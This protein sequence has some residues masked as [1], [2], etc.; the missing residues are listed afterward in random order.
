MS[1]H[2]DDRS[3][4][5]AVIGLGSNIGDRERYIEQAIEFISSH[6]QIKLV[7]RSGIY[8]TEPVG[9]RDQDYFLN[10]AILVHT[11]LTPIL[12]L[13]YLLSVEKSLGRVRDMRW[14]PRTIDLDL[15]L[16]GDCRL[17]SEELTLPHPRMEERAFV[18]VPLKELLNNELWPGLESGLF[19]LGKLQG[20]EGVA[21]WK[22]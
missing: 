22:K 11:T 4:N 21:L 13:H 18:I 10:M 16:Y 9:L 1:Y 17:V 20:K 8:E 3:D 15:L 5:P 7:R 12:L 19:D 6:P 2:E 14:G